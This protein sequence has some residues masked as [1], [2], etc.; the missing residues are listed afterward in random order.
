[1]LGYSGA[2]RIEIDS[3]QKYSPV[4]RNAV[5][6]LHDSGP[7]QSTFLDRCVV[8]TDHADIAAV[9]RA[10]GAEVIDRP[11]ELATDQAPTEGALQVLEV[12]G[13]QGT[14]LSLS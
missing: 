1:M 11:A 8:P 13:R 7:K 5:T 4:E 9:A 12:L 3:A 6:G 10:H 14:G 2:R